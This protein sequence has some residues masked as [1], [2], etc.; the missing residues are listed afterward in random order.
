METKTT[1][2]DKTIETIQGLISVNI[3]S[4]DG[5]KEAAEKVEHNS[6]AQ[7][8]CDLAEQRNQQVSE[9][10]TLVHSNDEEA[11]D[12]GS[13]AAA[14]HR[15]WMD[16]RAA[17]GAGTQAMLDEAERGEDHIKAQYEEALKECAGSA[18]TD[19]LNRQYAAVK[20][21]HDRVRDL[22]DSFSA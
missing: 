21:A 17:F 14:A 13:M 1:L 20:N 19:V 10:R 11:E 8:F 22:R 12:A 5:F 18:V 9:L 4:R 6:V 3:D 7:L 16:L 15:A 2:T